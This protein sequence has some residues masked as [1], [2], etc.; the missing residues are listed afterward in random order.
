MSLLDSARVM[1]GMAVAHF[2]AIPYSSLSPE[3]DGR[4]AG[5]IVIK[6]AEVE[7]SS[8]TQGSITLLREGVL[9]R[10]EVSRS[11]VQGQSLIAVEHRYREWYGYPA[12]GLL[13]LTLP[14]DLMI[15]AVA[16]GGMLISMPVVYGVRALRGE[17]ASDAGKAA[18][19]SS[20]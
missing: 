12:Q 10:F 8:A 20:P 11:Q 6:P 19:T 14:L 5:R 16:L 2:A 4:P 3:P 7:W 18:A 13:L 15:D 1:P 9:S 17:E